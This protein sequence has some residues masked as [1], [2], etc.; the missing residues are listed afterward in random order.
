[1]LCQDI[2]T[3]ME[4]SENFFRKNFSVWFTPKKAI[5]SL[6]S[7]QRIKTY[8]PINNNLL[9][10]EYFVHQSYFDALWLLG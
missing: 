8:T 4:N 6:H 5:I 10:L 2:N 9:D 7:V 3:Y 1:M